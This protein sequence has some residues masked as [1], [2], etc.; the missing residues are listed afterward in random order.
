[1]A[2]SAR[3]DELKKKFEDNPRRFFAP[4]ANEYRKAG[5]LEQAIALCR[6]HLP[7]QTAHISGHIVLAQALYEAGSTDESRSVFEASLE[8]DPENLIAL[9][10]LGDL[11]R[12]SGDVSTARS[13]YTRMLEVD[14][15][16]DEIGHLIRSIDEVPQPAA[17]PESTAPEVLGT[18]W[19]ERAAPSAEQPSIG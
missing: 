12:E 15:R 6:A 19:E 9:R 18:T 1:M 5:D 2:S 13:W 3:I 7:N 14:P 16:N 11:A 4:L 17:S 10:Y 8:L